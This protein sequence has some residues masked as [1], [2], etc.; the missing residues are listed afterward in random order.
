MQEHLISGQNLMWGTLMPSSQILISVALELVKMPENM[1][2]N[3]NFK[4]SLFHDVLAW[5]KAWLSIGYCF[6]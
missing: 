5:P 3:F 4:C 6:C 1:A 2:K